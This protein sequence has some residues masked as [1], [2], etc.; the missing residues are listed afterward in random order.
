MCSAAVTAFLICR[1]HFPQAPVFSPFG[2][3]F[4]SSAEQEVG[5]K[6]EVTQAAFPL[7]DIHH[8]AVAHQFTPL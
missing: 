4:E 8:E 5:V 7:T 2:C 6:E 3:M 1:P